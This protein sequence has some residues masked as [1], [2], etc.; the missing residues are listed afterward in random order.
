MKK[1][2]T[3]LLIVSSFQLAAQEESFDP[4]VVDTLDSKV[5]RVSLGVKVGI[6]N[7]AGVSVE[8]VTPL[9]DNRIAPY[10]DYS[11]FTVNPDES[12]VSLSYN[13]FGANI[14][15][16]NKGKGVYAGI[17]FGNLETDI[18]FESQETEDGNT[19]TFR[20]EIT[21]SLKSTNLKI[22]VKTGG[23]IYFRLELGYG[24]ADVP[25]GFDVD[26]TFTYTLNGQ[27]ITEQSTQTEDFPAI[28]GV[29]DSGILIGNFGFGIS[30]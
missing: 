24:I 28:P 4:E 23:R 16:G 27:Q 9:L 6:P 2:F 21:N 5:K 30:F 8:G 17:G 15:F 20:G 1:L 18:A 10:F 22:G 26:G 13:E 29:G 19:G 14:Y 11:G 12:E 3:L 25:T 7:I